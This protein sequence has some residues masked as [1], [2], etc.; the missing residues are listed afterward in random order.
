MHTPPYDPD[1]GMFVTG[2]GLLDDAEH[3]ASY[4]CAGPESSDAPPDSALE[5]ALYTQHALERLRRCLAEVEALAQASFFWEHFHAP[6]STAA[7]TH[8][9]TSAPAAQRT[10]PPSPPP[11]RR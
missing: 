11:S 10:P 6:L 2:P 8:P 1:A 7:Q 3:A 4:P 5:Q 9:S